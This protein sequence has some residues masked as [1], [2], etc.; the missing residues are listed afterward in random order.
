LGKFASGIGVGTVKEPS[1]SENAT[2]YRVP[3]NSP[4]ES[5]VAAAVAIEVARDGLGSAHLRPRREI[6][7]AESIGVEGPIAVGE[8]DRNRIPTG[9][10]DQ[11]HVVF[12]VAV[13]VT[14]EISYPIHP[15]PKGDSRT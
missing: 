7:E 10:T 15:I 12:S 14:R 5:D 2:G 6:R 13:E 11:G 9:T 1:P 3:T 8:R 4:D